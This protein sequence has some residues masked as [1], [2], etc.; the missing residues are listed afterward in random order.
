MSDLQGNL[1]FPS[2]KRHY[3]VSEL[4]S[5]I[6]NLL[7]V[8]FGDIW[9]EGEISDV[10]LS[11]LG[12]YYFALKEESS[13]LQCVCFR[14]AA[15]VLRIKPESGLSVVARGRVDVYAP[16]GQYQFVVEAMELRGQGA[17]Q[18]AFEQLKRKLEAEGLFDA[19]RK[20]PLPALPR[21]IG[22]V[23]SP[24]GAA[25][26][27]MISVLSRR[28]PGIHIRVY[29]SMVQGEE[30]PGQLAEG[31]RYFSEN[32][33]ADL[34]IVGRG[35]GSLEDLWA[36]NT[37][38]VARAIAACRVPVIS[39]VGH[40][41]DFSIADFVAD[42]RA[43]T[44]SVAAELAVPRKAD[45]LE[46]VAKLNT[47]LERTLSLVILQKARRLQA[48]GADRAFSTLHRRLHAA[49]QRLDDMD[50]RLRDAIRMRCANA[51]RE[52]EKVYGRLARLDL[53]VRLAGSRQMLG[54]LRQRLMQASDSALRGRRSQLMV[55]SAQLEGLS[56]LA[57]LDRGYSL[58]YRED[59]KL[60]SHAQT[61]S[62][63]EAVRLRFAQG[64]AVAKVE[65]IR[66]SQR[67]S[68]S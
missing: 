11:R 35:G 58:V 40:E 55:L 44:P 33:W 41:T 67:S 53:R 54:D 17:L 22:I 19:A 39:A 25:I 57:I 65:E 61:L 66:D 29:P 20:R 34:V 43:P 23:T 56:P 31:L 28:F 15:R 7:A 37:E 26:Q 51:G 6:A 60:V 59:G 32:P 62:L 10:K 16:R 48:V 45:L 9:V 50:F 4:N 12:H 21:R 24:T 68:E 38:E 30:A 18:L 8:E 36:F 47:M 49:A 64:E 63:G 2:V 13:V 14:G 1:L 5:E 42:L 46:T 3:R 52:F 27:D